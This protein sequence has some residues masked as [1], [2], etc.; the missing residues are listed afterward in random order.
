MHLPSVDVGQLRQRSPFF[1]HALIALS[2]LYM[3]QQEAA[4]QGFTSSGTLSD[5]HTTVARD[6]SRQCVDEPSGKLD[7]L[8]SK[9]DRTVTNHVLLVS[10]IQANLIL[11]LRELLA[12][13]LYK[14]W[15]FTGIAIRQAQALRLGVEYHGRLPSRLKEV[16]RRTYWAAFAMDR[17]VS[18]YCWRPQMI[19]SDCVRLNL[20][21]PDMT[22]LL[23]ESFSAP[24]LKTFEF[25]GAVSRLG[26]APYFISILHLWSQ[27]TYFHVKGD[28][29]YS[30]SGPDDAQGFFNKHERKIDDVHSSLPVPI[31][32]SMPNWRLFCHM[33][34]S[35]LFVNIHLLLN[36]AT[37][38]MHQE[39][40]PYRDPVGPMSTHPSLQDCAC[41]GEACSRC[42]E[43]KI[44]SRCLSSSDAIIGVMK[45]LTCAGE[46]HGRQDLQSVF[47]AGALLSA[48]NIQLW[49]HYVPRE[50]E[51]RKDGLEMVKEIAAV[52][53]SWKSQWPVADTWI[54]TLE[55]LCRLYQSI[56]APA[57]S[58]LE[59]NPREGQTVD[60]NTS[61]PPALSESDAYEQPY[62][63]LTEGNGL[64]D[65]D[66]KM[67]DKI[68]FILL[69]SLEDADA[70][71][72]VLNASVSPHV[73]YPGD[74]DSFPDDVEFDFHDL[75][76]ND[77][78][79]EFDPNY[80]N[81]SII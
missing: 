30:P 72:R 51:R 15:I 27:A 21:C 70:R 44:I 13:T 11:A 40:L 41:Q 32:W 55:A 79:P 16:Q 37:C 48:A 4:D 68:K 64:P 46:V 20:P 34:Q 9:P 58:L 61:A 59:E 57:L 67:N 75:D 5:W 73:D 10:S 69:A 76:T 63:R 17:M 80:T 52:F 42:R 38:V 45:D 19:D 56:Y 31:R 2:A 8:Q 71:D 53:Q 12:R 6:Y 26:L 66:E 74:Y 3:T 60:S 77:I 54:S 29:R 22:F 35:A 7:T 33:D 62:P 47:A 65:L 1:A 81:I 28:R 43:G 49:A 24:N 23:Q 50:Q 36:H 78:W 14:A 18:Y 39:Y 25:P